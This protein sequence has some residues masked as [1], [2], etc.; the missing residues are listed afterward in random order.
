MPLLDLLTLEMLSDEKPQNLFLLETRYRSG[1]KYFSQSLLS[2]A[3]AGMAG[4]EML[5]RNYW[6]STNSGHSREIDISPA[7]MNRD[8]GGEYLLS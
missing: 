2:I 7:E 8:G 6:N 4:G 5:S 1:N 3:K